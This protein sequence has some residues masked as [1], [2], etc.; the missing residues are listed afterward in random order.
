MRSSYIAQGIISK[1]LRWNMM[2]D[3]MRKI[4]YVYAL[5]RHFAVQQQLTQHCK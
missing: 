4:M 1:L 3:N 2:E 5:L